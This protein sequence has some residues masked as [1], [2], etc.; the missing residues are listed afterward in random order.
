V[1]A[2]ERGPKN[3]DEWRNSRHCVCTLWKNS[4]GKMEIKKKE[5]RKGDH[6]VIG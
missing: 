6:N 5:G 4:E 2:G 1:E 3:N